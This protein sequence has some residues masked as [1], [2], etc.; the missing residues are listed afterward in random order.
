MGKDVR[1]RSRKMLASG[2]VCAGLL[3][4]A[5]GGEDVQSFDEFGQPVT[6]T[7]TTTLEPFD[8]AGGEVEAT[9]EEL[10][11]VDTFD[12]LV[13]AGLLEGEFA[14]QA[15]QF[16]STQCSVLDAIETEEGLLTSLEVRSDETLTAIGIPDLYE[17]PDQFTGLM[18][19]SV[20]RAA[21][22]DELARVLEFDTGEVLAHSHLA[23]VTTD[24]G[25]THGEDGHV[26]E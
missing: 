23:P 1:V 13:V 6:T 16:V 20:G 24:A 2:V 9:I 3:L 10:R 15:D 5:C 22:P 7:T 11:A 14:E 19:H 18:L 21:C 26:H 17:M 25:H 8:L 12:A 4:A